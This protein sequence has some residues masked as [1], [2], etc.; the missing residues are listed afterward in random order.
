MTQNRRIGFWLAILSAIFFSI[1]VPITK[2]LTAFISPYWL[3]S[4]LYFGAGIGTLLYQKFNHHKKENLH[5]KNQTIW[6]GL[7][8]LLDIFA[9]IF[10][11]I[12]VK[13]TSG[14]MVGLLSNLELLFTFMIALL[15]FNERLRYRAWIALVMIVLGVIIANANGV[16][17]SFQFGQL[18][19]VIATLL[20]GLENNVSKKLSVGNPLNVVILKGLGTGIGTLVI[21]LLLQEP[22]PNIGYLFV[23][24]MG[25]FVVYGG[26]LIFYVNAQRNLEAALV[27]MV[28]SFAPLFG[29][30][31]AFFMFQETIV[32]NT[33][34]GY[35]F[36]IMALVIIGVDLYQKPKSLR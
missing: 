8:I 13:E 3:A 34:I 26:S 24:L 18:W 6:F 36:V 28:Q 31:I 16:Q 14:G 2:W 1:N 9:P 32:F 33:I 19:I 21:S 15:L 10:F 25:G 35:L 20:W 29:G 23:A 30:I 17:L 5:V 4:L 12:G 11:L 22:L 7:M 27:Q